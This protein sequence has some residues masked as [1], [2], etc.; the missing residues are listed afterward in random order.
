MTLHLPLKTFCLLKPLEKKLSAP[1]KFT[2]FFF[3]FSSYLL[4]FFRFYCLLKAPFHQKISVMFLY[5]SDYIFNLPLPLLSKRER[6]DHYLVMAFKRKLYDF[7]SALKPLCVARR[8]SRTTCF[9][10]CGRF[11]A[12]RYCAI[13]CDG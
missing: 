2:S 11:F 7:C 13:N 10:V 12:Y 6:K 5:M 1:L 3:C 9:V 8:L 4:L